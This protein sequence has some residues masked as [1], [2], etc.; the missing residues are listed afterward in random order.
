[1]LLSFPASTRAMGC[2]GVITERRVFCDSET[3]TLTLL[4]LQMERGLPLPPMPRKSWGKITAYTRREGWFE[5]FLPVALFCGPIIGTCGTR[6]VSRVII[7]VICTCKTVDY[8][9]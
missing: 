4:K 2:C 7:F 5:T 1:M 9:T 3:L 6:T 8:H